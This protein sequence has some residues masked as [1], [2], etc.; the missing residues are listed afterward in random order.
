MARIF[1]SYAR[2]DVA[3]AKLLKTGLDGHGHSVV[4]DI[5]D[6]GRGDWAA[7]IEARIRAATDVLVLVGPAALLSRHVGDE[8]A[9]A[10]KLQRPLMPVLLGEPPDTDAQPEWAR[11]LLKNQAARYDP[12][13]LEVSLRRIEKL[14]AGDRRRSVARGAAAAVGA[15]A[16]AG[17]AW[18][19]LLRPEPAGSARPPPAGVPAAGVLKITF[20]GAIKREQIEALEARLRGA[21]FQVPRSLRDEAVTAN[22]VRYG[23]AAAEP[24]ARQ[25]LGAVQAHFDALGCRLSAPPQTL[26]APDGVAAPNALQVSVFGSCP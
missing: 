3:V 7:Q 22:V 21:G 14:L 9:L 15:L 18:F 24:L 16:V 23:S 4:L 11:E 1:I 12:L 25:A 8:V 19:T 5:D 10:L 6:F 20:R 26:L 2:E 13:D 17:V